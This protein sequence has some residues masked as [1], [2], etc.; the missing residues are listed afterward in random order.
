MMIKSFVLL[1]QILISLKSRF[2]FN[3]IKKNPKVAKP[4][5]VNVQYYTINLLLLEFHFIV[6]L[7]LSYPTHCC[8]DAVLLLPFSQ[9]IPLF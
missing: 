8:K 1:K 3:G 9:C 6:L 7:K 4:R 2:I 5:M